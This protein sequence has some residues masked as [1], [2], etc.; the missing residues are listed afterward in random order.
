MVVK[1]HENVFTLHT[2]LTGMMTIVVLTRRR[3][4]SLLGFG[5]RVACLW[6]MLLLL[7]IW[8][9]YISIFTS[10]RFVSCLVCPRRISF[11]SWFCFC[12][13]AVIKSHNWKKKSKSV[14][15]F[16]TYSRETWILFFYGK[17]KELIW[18]IGPSNEIDKVIK[19]DNSFSFGAEQNAFW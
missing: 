15:D 16:L 13:L 5:N 4:T 7:Y 17:V 14:F 3:N 2:R 9:W 11:P 12:L 8:L 19:F 18:L 6:R 10:Q 1:I